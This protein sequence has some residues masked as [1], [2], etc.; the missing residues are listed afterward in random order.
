MSEVVLVALI[1]SG[2]AILAAIVTHFFATRS[3]AKQAHI[4]AEREALAWARSQDAAN[5]E[6]TEKLVRELWSWALQ[7]QARIID[8]LAARHT[9]KTGLQSDHSL[10]ATHAAAQAYA[11][12]LL[13]MSDVQSTAK[14]FYLA[15]ATTEAF[16]REG[17]DQRELRVSEWREAFNALEVAVSKLV[18][19]LR[20]E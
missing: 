19:A 10:S 14:A 3:A 18:P 16:L 2:S 11:V 12:S 1:S 17:S 9:A 7:A 15:T 20:V 4:D 8:A 13:G 6:K 5:T